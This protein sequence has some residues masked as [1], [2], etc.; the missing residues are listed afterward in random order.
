MNKHIKKLAKKLV[1]QIDGSIDTKKFTKLLEK[2]LEESY[3]RGRDSGIV[4]TAMACAGIC[5]GHKEMYA[6]LSASDEAF[7]T[8]TTAAGCCADDIKKK[9]GVKQ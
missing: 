7:A 6:M 8:M 9:F 4:D 2:E 3:L 1:E 5:E